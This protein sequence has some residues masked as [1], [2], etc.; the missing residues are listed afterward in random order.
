MEPNVIRI[1]PVDKKIDRVSLNRYLQEGI[2]AQIGFVC[3][4]DKNT[5]VRIYGVNYAVYYE[6][7]RK[8]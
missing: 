7:K 3:S 6:P 1:A 5:T 8:D 2:A 4:S